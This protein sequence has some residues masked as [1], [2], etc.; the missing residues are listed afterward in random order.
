MKKYFLIIC[1]IILTNHGIAFCAPADHGVSVNAGVNR[2]RAMIGDIVKFTIEVEY[3]ADVEIIIP[4]FKDGKIGDFEIKDQ[5]S[6]DNK[7][8]FSNAAVAR[9]WYNLAVYSVG[10][11]QIPQIDIKIRKK[12]GKDW[13]VAKTRAI[14]IKIDSIL[15]K[16]KPPADIKDVKGP[17][18]YFEINRL[19]I[20]II[21]LVL[22][23]IA[24][25]AAY[26]FRKK[27]GPVKLPHETALEELES[28]RGGFLK[29]SDF[30]E[31][32]AAISDC[33]RR[34]IERTFKLKAP[35]M[36]TE[37]FLESLRESTVIPLDQ[38]DLLKVFLSA[39]DLVKFA[40]YTPAR[41]EMEEVM[42]SAK[43]FIE[44]AVGD[45]GV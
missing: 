8:P 19:I 18:R 11:N 23:I 12:G 22:S 45:A 26:L 30:K 29:N 42:A 33:V 14:D 6:A 4:N 35:E 34:Y 5:G 2:N 41:N 40:K 43:K 17:A 21:V 31:Y 10:K 25:G 24:G 1:L 9:R 39:C 3:P 20:A 13:S 15:P 36:T 16:D 44:K 37:E 38:K 28:A 27:T 32:Y 7:E